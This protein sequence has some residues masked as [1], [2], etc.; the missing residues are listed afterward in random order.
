MLEWKEMT[1]K[2]LQWISTHFGRAGL[3]TWELHCKIWGFIVIIVNQ[4]AN[5]E[6]KTTSFISKFDSKFAN[7]ASRFE[8]Y[9]D[10]VASR[11]LLVVIFC[12]MA[13]NPFVTQGKAI[14]NKAREDIVDRWLNGTT[15]RQIGRDLNI[16]K[17]KISSTILVN[18]DTVTTKLG[19]TRHG[20]QEPKML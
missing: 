3:E 14:P 13:H 6:M 16:P 15:Q 17:S 5:F 7:F 4:I 8:V 10:E 19:E 11:L 9:Q 20:L 18:V 2:V 1:F 12:T